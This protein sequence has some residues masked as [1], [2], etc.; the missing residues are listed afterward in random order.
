M[1]K[2]SSLLDQML[3]EEQSV[4]SLLSHRWDSRLLGSKYWLCARVTSRIRDYL[5]DFRRNV[6][7]TLLP[8]ADA[9]TRTIVM[10]ASA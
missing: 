4:L 3:C 2:V 9:P 1:R 7:T 10:T 8:N 6:V 5:E